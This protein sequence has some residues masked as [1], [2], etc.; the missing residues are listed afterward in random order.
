MKFRDIPQF[1]SNGSY[2]VDDPVALSRDKKLTVNYKVSGQ[3][4][5]EYTAAWCNCFK[6][7]KGALSDHVGRHNHHHVCGRWNNRS[8]SL[9]IF[10]FCSALLVSFSYNN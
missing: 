5:I 9:V 10:F 4:A 3:L 8:R 7:Y 6:A 1:I 2:C